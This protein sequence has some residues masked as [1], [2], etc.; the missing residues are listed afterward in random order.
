M[1]L[2]L[3]LFL[4]LVRANAF[5]SNLPFLPPTRPV[6]FL[7]SEDNTKELEQTLT[8]SEREENL[9]A[10]RQIFKYDLADL[11]RRRDYAGWMESKKELKKRQRDDPWFDLNAQMKEATQ[12]DDTKEM[13]RLNKLIEKV[14]GP[15]PGVTP[16]REY[17]VVT[18]I[19]DVGMSIS[20]AENI[21]NYE[22]KKRNSIKWKEMMAERVANEEAE[23]EEYKANPYK[24]EED[25]NKRREKSMTTI[26]AK[27]EERRKKA[28]EKA[29]E[30]QKKYKNEDSALERA[31]QAAK[32]SQSKQLEPAKK[33]KDTSGRPRL[34]GD[35]DVTRGEVVGEILDCSDVTGKDLR[36]Q[37]TS[38]YNE[39]QS[40]P[41]MRKHCFQY[42]IKITNSS[43]TETVQLLGRRFEIQTVGS[44]MKDVVQGEGVTGR[45]PV[46]K[47]G[48]VFEYTSTAPLSVRPIGTT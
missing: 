21:A 23:E 15:P 5:H 36:V 30:I 1:R 10:M 44:S 3:P 40:D 27:I 17:A 16:K 26:Y 9:S 38:S 25:A 22:Q 37:V 39:E 29:K 24:D 48:E 18:E 31:L 28:E 35:V 33:V 7:S 43:P 14:G 32:K 12:I 20:R 46:L 47:P 4:L 45:T 13:E 2:C 19:Y 42:T 6:L 8:P 34:P 41:P 11:Q